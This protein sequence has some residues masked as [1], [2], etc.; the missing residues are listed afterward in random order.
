[1]IING[2]KIAEEIIAELKKKPES[3]KFL[4][5][6]QVGDEPT[7]VS[8]IKQKEK[9]AKITGVGFQIYKY[10]ADIK[11]DELKKEVLKIVGDENCGGVILQLPLP[12]H[13]NRDEIISFLPPGKDVDNLT[14]R[15]PVLPPAAGV[16]EKILQTINYN[17]QTAKVAVVGTGLL[18]GKP[19]SGW[20]K[21]KCSE[22]RTLSSGDDLGILKQA[23][24][25]ISGVGSAGLI[26]PE[27]LKEGAVVI[28]FGYDTKDGKLSGDFDTDSTTAVTYTPTP[29]G[30]GPVL[31][32]K[33]FENFYRLNS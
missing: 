20:L 2:E 26:K 7:M 10:P 29:G 24:L 28:D 31:V 16:V 18:V 32:A 11:S 6:V 17:P 23:D 22:L 9:I 14:G 8:F 15:A 5:V 33:V 21:S 13:I 4:A 3:K 27:V 25:V 12:G 1:M 30:T 19:V